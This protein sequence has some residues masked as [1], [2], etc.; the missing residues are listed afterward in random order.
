MVRDNNEASWTQ[1]LDNLE[2]M[3]DAAKN[4]PSL[5]QEIRSIIKKTRDSDFRL[6]SRA[7]EEEFG[8]GVVGDAQQLNDRVL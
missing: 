3:S 5:Y 2:F 7:L 4:T 1:I 8:F 6:V